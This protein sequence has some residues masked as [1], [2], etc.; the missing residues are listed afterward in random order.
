[1]SAA[2][3]HLSTSAVQTGAVHAEAS[4]TIMVTMAV[5]PRD[6]LPQTHAWLIKTSHSPRRKP[7]DPEPPFG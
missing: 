6:R 5:C 7:G 1:V 4:S 3:Q 2:E